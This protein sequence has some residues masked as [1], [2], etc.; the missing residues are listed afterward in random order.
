MTL[1]CG[2]KAVYWMMRLTCHMTGLMP[3]VD[4]RR[5]WGA[6]LGRRERRMGTWQ[7]LTS[8]EWP[9]CDGRGRDCGHSPDQQQGGIKEQLSALG[10]GRVPST[11]VEFPRSVDTGE[12]LGTDT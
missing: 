8:P 5:E 9:A 2:D 10:V 12:L 1:T 6:Y 4:W 11:A 7:A 3:S